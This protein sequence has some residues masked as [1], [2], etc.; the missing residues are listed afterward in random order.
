MTDAIRTL[1][2]LQ[3]LYAD[4]EVQA[5]SPQDLRDG[6]Y[7]SLGALPYG[8]L[9]ASGTLTDDQCVVSV[10]AGT[11]EVTVHLPSA[12]TTR[13]GKLYVLRKSDAGAGGTLTVNPSGTET[14]NTA[15]TKSIT[16][17]YSAMGVINTGGLDWVGFT[18]A[19]L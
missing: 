9:T 17:Q 8:T 4:N 5:I 16:T 15:A 3:T 12:L 11:V 14:V 13:A 10:T 6:F 19:L 7:S 18:L 2:A 1:T